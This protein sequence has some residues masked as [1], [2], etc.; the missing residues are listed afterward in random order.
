MR[1]FIIDKNS[2]GI[3]LDKFMCSVMPN[4]SFGEAC[5]ALRKK[6]VRVNGKHKGGTHRVSNG[7]HIQIYMNDEFFETNS[8]I[9]DFSWKN[10]P[11]DTDIEYEDE[12]ILIANKPSGLPS[13]A[14]GGTD[15]LENRIRAMLFK[16]G[17]ID[18]TATPIFIPSLCHRIDRNTSGLVL[19][20]KNAAA[21]R[22]ANRLIKDKKIRKFYLCQAEKTPN[23]PSGEICGWLVKDETRH[24]M[25]F[26]DKKPSDPTAA[27]CRTL[28]RVIKGGTPCVIEAELLTGRT[29]QIRASF[30]HIGCPLC[31]DVKYGA[32]KTADKSYQRLVSYKLIFDFEPCGSPLDYLSHKTFELSSLKPY[33]DDKPKDAEIMPFQAGSGYSLSANR[34]C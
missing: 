7:E 28:Y 4:I 10:C 22:A 5:K 6:K 30:S 19:A 32:A 18:I 12:N 21:L 14:D 11:T 3:R 16:K 25:K 34:P 33:K 24:K 17:E 15:S 20:A 9:H 26:F 23:P 31:G 29:H 1:E 13:Q 27:E 8:P 2:D